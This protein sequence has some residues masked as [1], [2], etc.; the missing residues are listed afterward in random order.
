[1]VEILREP[2]FGKNVEIK[3]AGDR[4]EIESDAEYKS[5]CFI[6]PFYNRVYKYEFTIDGNTFETEVL[7]E[8]YRMGIVE[9]VDLK[10]YAR[11]KFLTD[12]PNIA[13]LAKARSQYIPA[14]KVFAQTEKGKVVHWITYA[15]RRR[16]VTSVYR[17]KPKLPKNKDAAKMVE[18]VRERYNKNN[19]YVA[20]LID[21]RLNYDTMGHID[22][23]AIEQVSDEIYQMCSYKGKST[24][25]IEEVSNIGAT[26][27]EMFGSLLG[28]EKYKDDLV[29][30]WNVYGDIWKEEQ[31]K[32]IEYR[33]R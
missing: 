23:K 29:K 27:E 1:M 10:S 9:T 14:F 16:S 2:L 19:Y 22:K 11:K 12:S 30:M 8:I 32:D 13:Q 5:D 3:R 21:S 4:V 24:A 33:E 31:D 20:L 15:D 6:T 26:V 25:L 17:G 7:G 28:Y 18:M